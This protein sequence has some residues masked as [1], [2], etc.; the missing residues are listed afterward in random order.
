MQHSKYETP[1]QLALDVGSKA[2]TRTRGLAY[3]KSP[4]E[5]ERTAPGDVTIPEQSRIEALVIVSPSE[6]H[7]QGARMRPMDAFFLEVGC[8]HTK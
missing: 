5:E 4:R 2:I 6:V 3:I 1:C 7:H 8:F